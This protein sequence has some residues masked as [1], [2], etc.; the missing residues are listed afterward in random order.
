M[1][2]FSL[3]P[4]FFVY[5]CTTIRQSNFLLCVNVLALN[6]ILTRKCSLTCLYINITMYVFVLWWLAKL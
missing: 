3:S 5:V 2:L 4:H 6:W 1:H